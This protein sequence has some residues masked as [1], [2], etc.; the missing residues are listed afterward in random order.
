MRKLARDAGLSD[1]RFIEVFRAEVGLNPKLF[2]RIARFQGV[3]EKVDPLPEPAWE[4]VALE[5]GYFD[6]SH[7]IRDFVEFSGFQ[8]GRLFSMAQGPARQGSTRQIQPPSGRTVAA[9]FPNTNGTGI[10]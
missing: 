6:Q 8:P 4:Q 10:S 5:Y 9:I 1:R 7:L 3:L 2:N